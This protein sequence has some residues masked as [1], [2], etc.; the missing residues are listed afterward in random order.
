MSGVASGSSSSATFPIPAS[1]QELESPPY[2]LLPYPQDFDDDDEAARAESFNKLI[3][4][5][6]GG[7][8][9]LLSSGLGLFEVEGDDDD[10]TND[11]LKTTAERPPERMADDEPL[12]RGGRI[13]A[14]MVDKG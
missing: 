8:R 2:N 3:H 13:D 12:D 1:L 6:E 10:A 11:D 14:I 5:L 4:H 7:N 9:V